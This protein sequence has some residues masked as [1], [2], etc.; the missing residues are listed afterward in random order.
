MTHV[1]GT[2]RRTPTLSEILESVT[3]PPGTRRV[4]SAAERASGRHHADQS[5]VAVRRC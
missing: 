5:A 4:R 2:V 1:C 3:G